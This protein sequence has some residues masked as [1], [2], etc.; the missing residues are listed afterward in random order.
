M[1]PVDIEDFLKIEKVKHKHRKPQHVMLRLRNGDIGNEQLQD[2]VKLVDG[3][4]RI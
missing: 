3:L 1:F 4:A 2:L